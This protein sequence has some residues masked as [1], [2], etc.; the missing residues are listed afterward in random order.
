[1]A[2]PR[3]QVIQIACGT[4][5]QHNP[6]ISGPNFIAN[7][8]K[9]SEQITVRGWGISS[10]GS[11]PDSAYALFQC[12]DDLSEL[13]CLLCYTEARTYLPK[14]YPQNGGRIFLDGCFVRS[15][16]YSFFQ[17]YTGKQDHSVC[18]KKNETI[19]KK[20]LGFENSTSRAV[21]RA[22]AMAAQEPNNKGFA[23]SQLSVPG[24][25]NESVF[26]LATCWKT[27]SANSCRACLENASRSILGCLPS[28]DGRALNTGCFMRYANTNFL[29]PTDDQRNSRGKFCF[30]FFFYIHLS[31]Y[32]V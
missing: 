21:F 1:M 5:L 25:S 11:G 16:N 20:D 24:A 7:M 32:L 22:A 6:T 13:D 30:F 31:F 29:N 8:Q 15:E 27:L 26:V 4:Q 10:T 3:D 28:S 17:E 9:I 2:E 12:H 19:G 23:H 18:G 14:C